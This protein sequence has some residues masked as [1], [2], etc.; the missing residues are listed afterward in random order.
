M[1]VCALSTLPRS[2]LPHQ[3]GSGG[4]GP[5][6]WPGTTHTRGCTLSVRLSKYKR[7]SDTQPGSTGLLQTPFGSDADSDH[8]WQNALW[9]PQTAVLHPGWVKGHSKQTQEILFKKCLT[10]QKLWAF[11]FSQVITGVEFGWD[12]SLHLKI[13]LRSHTCSSAWRSSA[14][15]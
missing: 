11:F 15:W 14:G 4:S 5:S 10:A 3:Q 13:L 9:T 2:P 1:T 6:L 8:H 12:L 7:A